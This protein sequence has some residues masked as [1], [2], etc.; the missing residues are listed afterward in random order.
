MTAEV[1]LPV[2][3]LDAPLEPDDEVVACRHCG[4]ALDDIPATLAALAPHNTG[5]CSS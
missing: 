4:T 2:C 1:L 5:R 3:E